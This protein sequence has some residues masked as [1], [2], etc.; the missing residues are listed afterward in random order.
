MDIRRIETTEERTILK[1]MVLNDDVLTT[2]VRNLKGNTKP[3]QR[4]FSDLV[5]KWIFEHYE[6]Y[7]VAPKGSIQDRL[8]EYAEQTTDEDT[9][10]MVE[11]FL[12]VLSDEAK[13][14]EEINVPYVV[15]MA[16]RYFKK[17]RHTAFLKKSLRSVEA[18]DMDRAYELLAH[19]EPIEFAQNVPG[20]M[21]DK[22]TIK[23]IYGK[24]DNE[25]MIQFPGALGTFM[26]RNF[27]RDAF[28][29]F[30]GPEKRGKSFWLMEIVYL[31]AKQKRNVLYYV[32]GDMSRDQTYKRFHVRASRRPKKTQTLEIPTAITQDGDRVHVAKE[33]KE[34]KGIT[35]K[36]AYEVMKE[37]K[38]KTGST[39]FRVKTTVA[40]AASLSAS[41][42]RSD[43]EENIKK[44]FVPDV[45]VIDYADI[46]LAEPGTTQQ[47]F[48]HQQNATWLMLRKISQDFHLCLVTAT[49]TA[50]SSYKANI[51]R[52]SDFSEDKRKAGHVTGMLGINQTSNEKV[53]GVYRLNWM[54]CRES[55]WAEHE[56]VT[57]A[58]N[59]AIG[60]PC[61]VSAIF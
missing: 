43:I 10:K 20:D 54:F 60:R 36:V 3:F 47:D 49:Q 51:I 61:I 58:G 14:E 15:D 12:R 45:V 24:G 42:I 6:K 59:L 26:G 52:A 37:F 13:A 23:E 40:S 17:V 8:V 22:E 19:H 30:A 2:I 16:S 9:V 35:G 56:C 25:Q 41:S 5:A 53:D 55:A 50:A 28:I 33:S 1:A 21:S 57:T 4:K 38:S 7:K 39:E 29:A 18:G 46:L 34:V 32:T 11:G 48:R 31:A 27:E 44:G